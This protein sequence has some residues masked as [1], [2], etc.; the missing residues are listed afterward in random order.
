MRISSIGKVRFYI[1]PYSRKFHQQDFCP[2]LMNIIYKNI[3]YVMQKC[4][5]GEILFSQNLWQCYYHPGS[6]LRSWLL[7][8]SVPVLSGVLSEP[9][10]SHFC[11]LVAATHIV[12]GDGIKQTDIKTLCSELSTHY[13]KYMY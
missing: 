7:Y 11:Y 8:Y 2:I 13:G 6:Q 10:F 5:A 12:L 4:L 1:I 9:Y 3:F